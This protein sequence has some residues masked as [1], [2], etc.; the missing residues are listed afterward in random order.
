M[1]ESETIVGGPGVEVEVDET[2]MG[3]RKYHRVYRIDGIWAIAVVE[4]PPDKIMFAVEIEKR[5]KI[6]IQKIL[7]NHILPGSIVLTDCFKSYTGA[8]KE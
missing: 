2:T 8:C 4:R 5:A 7:E 6:T 1:P 3:R